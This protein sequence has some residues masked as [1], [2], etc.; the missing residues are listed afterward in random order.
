MHI[1]R[2]AGLALAL[3]AV[4]LPALAQQTKDTRPDPARPS[5]PVPAMGYDSAF[6]DYVPDREVEPAGWKAV[7][8]EVGQLGGHMGHMRGATG[9]AGR[10]AVPGTK[11]GAKPAGQPDKPA[12]GGHAGHAK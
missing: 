3:T 9:G 12:A 4:P 1:F 10:S 6:R 11:P 5:A 2:I 8:E 7:N